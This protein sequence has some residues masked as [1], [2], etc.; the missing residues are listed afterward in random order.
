M[1]FDARKIMTVEKVAEIFERRPLWVKQQVSEGRLIPHYAG[2]TMFFYEDEVVGA[3]LDDKLD[4][5]RGNHQA[6]V[7][8]RGRGTPNGFGPQVLRGL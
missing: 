7:K 4:K 1:T 6:A 2:D 3:F 8:K 5:R